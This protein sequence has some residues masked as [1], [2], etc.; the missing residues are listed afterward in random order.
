MDPLE[1]NIDIIARPRGNASRASRC[2][3][4]VSGRS[5]RSP[6]SLRSTA[7]SSAEGRLGTWNGAGSRSKAAIR[8]EPEHTVEPLVVE[9]QLSAQRRAVLGALGIALKLLGKC[10][11]PEVGDDGHQEMQNVPEIRTQCGSVFLQGPGVAPE[12]LGKRLV[13]RRGQRVTDLI[14]EE[15]QEEWLEEP[16]LGVYQ[17]RKPLGR[18]CCPASST[19]V[20]RDA[21]V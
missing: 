5:P 12:C 18:G 8:P 20:V 15:A 9:T 3:R 2:C 21:T 14:Q 19:P 11:I 4:V 13:A 6:C 7:V 17:L 10:D 1:A 16:Q